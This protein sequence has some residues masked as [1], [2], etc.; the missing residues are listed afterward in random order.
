M[1][2][3]PSEIPKTP[4]P[5]VEKAPAPLDTA[6]KEFSRDPEH[7]EFGSANAAEQF[8]AARL[9]MAHKEFL[10]AEKLLRSVLTQSPY[11]SAA[12]RAMAECARALGK[13]DERLHVL[14]SLV[15]IDDHPE[16][17][18]Q[19]ADA[20]Y[21][22]G[23]DQE[24]LRLYL[25]AL[26]SMES[27]SPLMFDIYKSLGN[28]FVRCHDFESA[29]ENYN[30]AY[31]INP[32]SATLLVN[33]GTLEIQRNNWNEAVQ[34]FRDAID[35][36][37]D[38]DRAWVGLAI[39]HRQFGDIELSWANLAKAL[40]LNPENTTALQLALSWVVKDQ[41]WTVVREWLRK[42]LER[43]SDDAAISLALAQLSFLQ[44][45]WVDARV[46]LTRALSL[47]PEIAGGIELMRLIR[48]EQEK[49]SHGREQTSGAVD[50][51]K[52]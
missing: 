41:N 12:I 1:L 49:E 7:S 36:D 29:E 21:D 24:A 45:W 46:E 23:E 3:L 38:F 44:G 20:L 35:V 39:A 11:S 19:L 18:L 2:G 17:L 25:T 8:Q 6:L 34:R 30:K 27:D 37:Q 48:Q 42:Y 22:R 50:L 51:T 14:K 16:H 40:D 10:P 43:R 4:K 26:R 32:D 15:R 5:F 47:D 31:T 52:R 28:I 9:L 33:F 13:S